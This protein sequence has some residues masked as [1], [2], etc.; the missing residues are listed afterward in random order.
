LLNHLLQALRLQQEKAD[1]DQQVN[2]IGRAL[3][4]DLVKPSPHDGEGMVPVVCSYVSGHLDRFD[5]VGFAFHELSRPFACRR[6]AAS[7]DPVRVR[8]AKASSNPANAPILIGL[9]LC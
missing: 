3:A 7:E 1:L 5:A 8:V 9:R 2:L 6:L 4:H